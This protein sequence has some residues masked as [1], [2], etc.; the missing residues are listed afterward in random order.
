MSNYLANLA[1]RTLNLT[2]PVFPRLRGRYEPAFVTGER[3]LI[4]PLSHDRA[5][6]EALRV[7]TEPAAPSPTGR[8]PHP[9]P[10]ARNHRQLAS[11]SQE[12]SLGIPANEPGRDSQDSL[13][14]S[15]SQSFHIRV[16][17]EPPPRIGESPIE[18]AQPAGAL[19]RDN[20]TE[21][22]SVI[23]NTD[24]SKTTSMVNDVG[25]AGSS[26]FKPGTNS[27]QLERV[28][29]TRL[30]D[31]P[32][33][34]TRVRPLK[35]TLDEPE[36]EASPAT[37]RPK[38]RLA[39][40]SQTVTDERGVADFTPPDHSLNS[41]SS[42]ISRRRPGDVFASNVSVVI[43]APPITP[44]VEDRTMS[45]LDRSQSST[46]QP[47]VQVTIGRIEVRAVQ[48]AP[49]AASRLRAAPPVMN[50]DD[51]LRQRSGGTAR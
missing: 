18:R 40:H 50:L 29:G 3:P 42:T 34:A 9:K 27:F 35:A 51:Y 21:A 41:P 32:A 12:T 28:R 8:H 6:V 11:Q 39:A 15:R 30:L 4:Q 38:K 33:D 23:S 10:P 7:E 26:K 48:S 46:T 24:R 13:E 16:A 2:E 1:A 44:L 19:P 37:P 5:V 36:L 43:A 47:T 17:S 49:P 31:N 45:T 25:M 20:A 22:S 14:A